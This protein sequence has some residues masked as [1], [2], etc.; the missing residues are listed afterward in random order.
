MSSRLLNLTVRTILATIASYITLLFSSI[1]LSLLMLLFCSGGDCDSISLEGT[2]L[3]ISFV[4]SVITYLTIFHKFSSRELSKRNTA[5]NITEGTAMLIVS[6]TV[7]IFIIY[8]NQ[9]A[10]YNRNTHN[11]FEDGTLCYLKS[12]TCEILPYVQYYTRTKEDLAVKQQALLELKDGLI[13][14]TDQRLANIYEMRVFPVCPDDGLEHDYTCRSSDE[15]VDI[16]ARI[17]NA[18][19]SIKREVEVAESYISGHPQQEQQEEIE[20]YKRTHAKPVFFSTI[21]KLISE[22]FTITKPTKL[23]H[24]PIVQITSTRRASGGI[25]ITG[26]A[27]NL[28]TVYVHLGDT[29]EIF[30]SSGPITVKQ[31]TWSTQ[32]TISEYILMNTKPIYVIVTDDEEVVSAQI[33]VTQVLQENF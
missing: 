14:E 7:L 11:M 18:E 16:A 2:I 26:S 21:S 5:I 22:I 12:D 3:L 20:V 17:E 25:E 9:L 31:N 30:W 29:G 24:E 23:N 13:D 8:Q 10:E 27:N 28:N 1:A 4:P 19:K 6:L 32:A 33:K 15:K